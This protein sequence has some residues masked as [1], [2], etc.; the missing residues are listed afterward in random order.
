VRSKV[1][2]GLPPDEVPPIGLERQAWS[3]LSIKISDKAWKDGAI[4]K[5]EKFEMHFTAAVSSIIYQSVAPTDPAVLVPCLCC[6]SNGE[7]FLEIR[8]D[9][10]RTCAATC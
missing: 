6:H 9:R 5:D 7:R 4:K 1:S 10:C 2:K 3:K 8:A